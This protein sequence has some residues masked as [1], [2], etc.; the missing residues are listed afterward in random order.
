MIKNESVSKILH[1][2]EVILKCHLIS[3]SLPGFI[4]S[5]TIVLLFYVLG[6]LA[7]RHMRS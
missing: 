1:I 6:F 7:T 4:E 3:V 2:L 5:V